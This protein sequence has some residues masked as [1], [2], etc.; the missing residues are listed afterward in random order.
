MSYEQHEDFVL[1][2]R[3]LVVVLVLSVVGSLIL[4]AVLVTVQAGQYARELLAKQRAERARRLRWCSTDADVLAPSIASGEYHLFLSHVWGSG[5]DQM[6]IV[7]QRLLEMIPDLSIFL[8]MRQWLSSATCKVL[9]S[10]V[11]LM[12]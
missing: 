4:S 9:P 12:R 11:L 6:R 3:P 2:H 1:L 7:K 10:A 8:V 5:Q